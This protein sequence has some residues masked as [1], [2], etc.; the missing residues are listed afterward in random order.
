MVSAFFNDLYRFCHSFSE[1]FLDYVHNSSTDFNKCLYSNGTSGKS[2]K[3]F[4]PM[5]LIISM[6]LNIQRHT[7]KVQ[8]QFTK[9]HIL[10]DEEMT[11][12]KKLSKLIAEKNNVLSEQ[13]LR[14]T[15]TNLPFLI[16][17]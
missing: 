4:L 3:V 8:R 15:L 9:Q 14:D 13:A 17:N 10:L 12:S 2:I 1:I 11:K 16:I 6:G 7:Y 5:S